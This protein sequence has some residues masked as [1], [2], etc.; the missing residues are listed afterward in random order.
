MSNKI[1]VEKNPE[2]QKM[3]DKIKAEG[4]TIIE[5]SNPYP[6]LGAIQL[7]GFDTLPRLEQ[8]TLIRASDVLARY[9]NTYYTI[10]RFETDHSARRKWRADMANEFGQPFIDFY[11]ADKL[12]RNKVAP[13]Q[14]WLLTAIRSTKFWPQEIDSK[15]LK[16]LESSVPNILS[17]NNLSTDE[18]IA[19]ITELE[20]VAR[21]YLDILYVTK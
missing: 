10:D 19:L 5:E 21:K 4:V 9:I 13:A 20:N 15:S 8:D 18:K 1:E 17:Y 12:R 14:R 2:R 6:P 16:L 11:Q 7:P 3:F